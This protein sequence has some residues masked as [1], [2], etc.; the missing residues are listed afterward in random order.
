MLHGETKLARAL[1]LWC[2][3]QKMRPR[4]QELYL[5]EVAERPGA[6]QLPPLGTVYRKWERDLCCSLGW[7]HGGDPALSPQRPENRALRS[8][9]AP[10]GGSLFTWVSRSGRGPMWPPGSPCSEC[11]EA[12][13]RR[14]AAGLLDTEAIICLVSEKASDFKAMGWERWGFLSS[15]NP[16]NILYCQFYNYTKPKPK[17]TLPSWFLMILVKMSLNSYCEAFKLF[18]FPM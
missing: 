16:Q 12:A 8:A 1:C 3:K 9:P 18:F 6:Q 2:S 10:R 17:S 11:P 13:V 5:G 14:Q 4:S 15:G 7:E